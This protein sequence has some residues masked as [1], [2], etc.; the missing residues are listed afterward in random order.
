MSFPQ[1]KKWISSE[2]LLLFWFTI[3]IAFYSGL[4]KR[5]VTKRNRFLSMLRFIVM[6]QYPLYISNRGFTLFFWI[7][8]SKRNKPR[9]NKIKMRLLFYR[10]A[11]RIATC[12]QGHTVP[13]T[14]PAWTRLNFISKIRAIRCG[15]AQPPHF[16]S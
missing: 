15:R 14:Y 8:K 12:G 11:Q 4:V 1:N 7:K 2:I 13:T 3:D 16:I 5:W 10:N 9:N 6:F